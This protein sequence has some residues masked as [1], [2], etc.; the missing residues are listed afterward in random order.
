[1]YNI[2]HTNICTIEVPEV[3]GREKRTET[4]PETIMAGNSSNLVKGADIQVK[5]VPKVQT[6]WTEK[7]HT[8]T[9]YN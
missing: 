5:E 3:E 7:T 6:R 1:M 9:Y 8:K 4:Q 2:K